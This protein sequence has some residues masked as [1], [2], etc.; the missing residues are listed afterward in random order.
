VSIVL[1]ISGAIGCADERPSVVLYASA[2][3]YVARELIAAFEREHDIRVR[4]VGDTEA[5]KTVGLVERL[6]A[7]KDNPQA[8]VFWSS[9]V[10]LTIELADEGIFE[11]YESPATTDW[12]ALFRD[13]RNRWYEFAAR[14]RV[15]VY[16]PNRLDANDIPETWMDLT[17]TQFKGRLV[18]A[19]PRFGT[20][21]GHLG[22]MKAYWRREFGPGFYQAFLMGL[23][24][25]EVRLISSG[26]A[27]VVRAVASG[28][29]DVGMT[30]TDDVWL[31]RDQGMNVEMV[32]PLHE[33]PNGT[34]GGGTLLIPNTVSRVRGGPNP[35]TAGAL[36]DFLLSE[37][38]ERLLAESSSRNIPLRP[39]LNEEYEDLHVP[40]PLDVD[41]RRAA[42]M[43][44][45]AIEQAMR[46]LRDGRVNDADDE[47]AETE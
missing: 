3:E 13:D 26:N 14:A 31:A 46:V 45:E 38:G 44:T 15:I 34:G 10:F 39:G 28:E 5:K 37:Q 36:I 25:N 11:S 32:Y 40:D 9:E 18:M 23:A 19:D 47:P 8:D 35:E 4:F 42:A 33:P 21:G 27:G 16:A 24:D 1:V 29:A 43:R 22:A 17:S 6:R 20:T 7:E 12:P 41:L 2:D 30:D